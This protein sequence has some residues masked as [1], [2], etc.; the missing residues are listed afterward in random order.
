M[1]TLAVTVKEFARSLSDFLNQVPYRRQVPDIERCKSVVAR[2][3]PVAA[4]DGFPID[5]LDAMLAQGPQLAAADRARLADDARKVRAQLS[6][7]RNR[8]M[9]PL[10]DTGV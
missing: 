6:K 3:A 7:A 2:V 1:A 4:V 5:R 10:I 9:R 8:P